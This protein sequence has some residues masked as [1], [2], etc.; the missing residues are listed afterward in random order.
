MAYMVVS[1]T[2]VKEVCILQDEGEF[3]IVCYKDLDGQDAGASGF[4]IRR[5]RIYGSREKAEQ[6]ARNLAIVNADQ[7]HSSLF[8]TEK[9]HHD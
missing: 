7:P 5:N 4:R 1:N 8:P 3:C 6:H 2:F 9:T